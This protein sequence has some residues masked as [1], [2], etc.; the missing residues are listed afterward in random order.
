MIR[1]TCVDCG[2]FTIDL[3]ASKQTSPG[4]IKP[5][6]SLAHGAWPK[7]S[8]RVA[9]PSPQRDRVS[10]GGSQTTAKVFCAPCW[11][12]DFAHATEQFVRSPR[13]HLFWT[14]TKAKQ[15][16]KLFAKSLPPLWPRVPGLDFHV[17]SVCDANQH[18]SERMAV[19]RVLACLCRR[20]PRSKSLIPSYSCSGSYHQ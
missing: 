12:Q 19:A 13:P 3:E 14:T 10:H 20:A 18:T 7:E 16:A 6:Q 9:A 17:F 15:M 4:T 1:P 2:S 8:E 5:C 11:R